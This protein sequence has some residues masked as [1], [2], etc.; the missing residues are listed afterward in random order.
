LHSALLWEAALTRRSDM[1]R[2]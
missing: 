1:G 2:V